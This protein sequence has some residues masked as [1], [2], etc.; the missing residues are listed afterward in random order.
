MSKL[1]RK[2]DVLR[3]K[4]LLLERGM[5]SREADE[6]VINA[7]NDI[8]AYAFIQTNSDKRL[9]VILQ[10]LERQF[11]HLKKIPKS[12]RNEE[13]NAERMK[14]FLRLFNATYCHHFDKGKTHVE[15]TCKPGFKPLEAEYNFLVEQNTTWAGGIAAQIGNRDEQQ[16]VILWCHLLIRTIVKST[17]A[18]EHLYLAF[19]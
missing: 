7:I 6:E 17:I 12:R 16:E 15:C 8:Y 10:T 4:K 3:Y 19:N 9:H 13:S 2:I 18:V 14:P 1:P 11:D 5:D